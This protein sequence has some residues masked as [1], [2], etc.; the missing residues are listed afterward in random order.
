[1]AAA[2]PQVDRLACLLC[3]CRRGAAQAESAGL[4][5][6]GHAPHPEQRRQIPGASGG[7]TPPLSSEQYV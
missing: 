7:M 5:R 1:M 3:G 6:A 2:T 4:E